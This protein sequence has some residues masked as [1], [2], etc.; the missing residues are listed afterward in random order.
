[1]QSTRTPACASAT[2][3]PAQAVVF[4]VPPLPDRTA[5][6]EPKVLSPQFPIL[7]HYK[8]ISH[9]KQEERGKKWKKFHYYYQITIG[10]FLFLS[11]KA[12]KWP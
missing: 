10:F 7:F 3:I 9:K 12:S 8:G 5:T 6:T 2:E 1:M 4:P 11:G